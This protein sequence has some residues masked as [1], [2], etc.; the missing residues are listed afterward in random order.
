MLP[1]ALLVHELISRVSTGMVQSIKF[2][3][4]QMTCHCLHYIP[5]SLPEL[6]FLFAKLGR[7]FSYKLSF[8]DN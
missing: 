1:L 8:Q 2:L 4:M 3:F 7:I 5:S 6:L